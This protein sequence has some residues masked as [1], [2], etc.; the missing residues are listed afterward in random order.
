MA[1]LPHSTDILDYPARFQFGQP[2]VPMVIAK[3]GCA[4]TSAQMLIEYYTEK[5]VTLN[6]VRAASGHVTDGVHGLSIPDTLRALHHFGVRASYKLD[7]DL[8]FLDGKCRHF[9]PVIIGVGYAK[10]PNWYKSSR[11]PRCERGG[12]T[13]INFV[14]AH[15]IVLRGKWQHYNETMREILHSDWVTRDPDHS[16]E[17][18]NLDRFNFSMLKPAMDALVSDTAWVNSFVIYPL[19][20]KVISPSGIMGLEVDSSDENTSTPPDHRID[21]A[22]GVDE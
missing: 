7:P 12:K 3:T 20:K 18:P 14:G 19:V 5:T 8:D 11:N 22:V 6:E 2:G 15:S 1:Q 9:G 17:K 10:Y 16:R 4:D 21:A 13:D